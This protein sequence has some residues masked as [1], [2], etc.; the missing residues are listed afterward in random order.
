MECN[1][2]KGK[3]SPCCEK[4]CRH[5]IN[6]KKDNNCCLITVDKHGRLTLREVA[7]RL[8]VSYVRIKQIQDKAISKISKENFGDE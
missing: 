7:D 8:G 2:E 5:W 6:Y 1:R 4:S 3:D